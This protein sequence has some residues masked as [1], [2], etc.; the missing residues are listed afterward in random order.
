MGCG[1][2]GGGCLLHPRCPVYRHQGGASASLHQ[3]GVPGRRQDRRLFLMSLPVAGEGGS[4]QT[5]Q[6]EEQTLST[7]FHARS[8][9]LQVPGAQLGE[10]QPLG[11]LVQVQSGEV[12]SG[13]TSGCPSTPQAGGPT[14][15]SAG[16]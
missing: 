10:P 4:E 7:C 11:R 3:P 6:V 13:Q 12:G 16:S 1:T 14:V 2:R 8:A 9:L 15:T 5:L